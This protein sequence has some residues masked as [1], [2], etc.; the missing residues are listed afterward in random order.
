MNKWKFLGHARKTKS[1][2]VHHS[3]SYEPCDMNTGDIPLYTA[4]LPNP[5]LLEFQ[6]RH[7][8]IDSTYTIN[9][10]DVEMPTPDQLARMPKAV[11][12]RQ[13]RYEQ[14][15]E[16]ILCSEGPAIAPFPKIADPE[17]DSPGWVTRDEYYARPRAIPDERPPKRKARAQGGRKAKKTKPTGEQTEEVPINRDRPT[18]DGDNPGSGPQEPPADTTEGSD[19]GLLEAAAG[20]ELLQQFNESGGAPETT[21]ES[22]SLPSRQKK[23][24]N[25]ADSAPPLQKKPTV[26]RKRAQAVKK[27]QAAIEIETVPDPGPPSLSEHGLLALPAIVRWQIYRHLLVAK[28]PIRVHAS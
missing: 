27:Q 16:A 22:E 14:T 26:R 5:E 18:P 4:G 1:V 19:S 17:D 28:E 21:N 8:T 13:I 6:V 3:P 10:I 2:G 9:R 11:R 12:R 25:E 15:D 24:A 23:S 7:K 20:L